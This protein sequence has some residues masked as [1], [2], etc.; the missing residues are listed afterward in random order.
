VRVPALGAFGNP[1]CLTRREIGDV[2]ERFSAAASAALTAGFDGV[3]IHAAH[4]Y[5]ISQFLSPLTNHRDDDR[6]GDATRRL[7]LLVDVV[8]A[9]RR[10]VG[11]QFPIGVKLNTADL[12]RGGFDE[13]ESLRVIDVLEVEAI[14]LLE[15]SGGTFEAG[16]MMGARNAERTRSREAYFQQFAE[17]ARGRAR[18]PLMLTGGFRT[19]D[20]M[21]HAIVS[22]TV[23]LI[24]LA[25]P[26]VVDPSFARRV[27]E[28]ATDGISLSPGA[29]TSSAWMRSRR[30]PGTRNR[31]DA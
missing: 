12:P 26:L 7:R 23:D 5:L 15:I 19:T 22:G 9:V 16:A 4:G 6:G 13:A 25:R 29:S 11:P 17:E 14:D 20:A 1:R 2:I 18:L 28:G 21:N 24:G 31:S 3:Q 10:A 8:R 27:L 30:L